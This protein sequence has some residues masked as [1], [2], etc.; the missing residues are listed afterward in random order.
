M[1]T[2]ACFG[3]ISSMIGNA[4]FADYLEGHFVAGAGDLA[5]LCGPIFG[6]VAPSLPLSCDSGPAGAPGRFGLGWPPR[7][8]IC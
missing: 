6:W 2:A 8:T 1:I 3:A 4:I 7:L 5:V